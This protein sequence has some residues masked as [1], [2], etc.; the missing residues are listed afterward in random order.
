MKNL[1]FNTYLNTLLGANEPALNFI[2][3]QFSKQITYQKNDIIYPKGRIPEHL[4][5][6]ERGNAIALSQSKPNRQVLRFWMA[7]Q[8]ICPCGFFNN[9]PST[10]S[11]VALDNCLMST[12]NYRQ[13]INFL[14][15]FPEAYK[16]INAI[17][18]AEINLVELNIKSIN[19]NTSSQNHEA[20]LEALALTFDE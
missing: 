16:I 13:L 2:L 20:L 10:Q 6:I 4:S 7:N 14:N 5:Y 11:I 15:D 12:L 8:L 3:S 1:T 17:L 18:K 9:T 19:Q